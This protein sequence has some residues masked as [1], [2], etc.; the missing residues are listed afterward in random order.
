MLA[1][2]P[3]EIV[4]TGR[5]RPVAGGARRDAGCGIAVL[6]DVLAARDQGGG[7]RRAGNRDLAAVVVR[8][9]SHLLV[10]EW[11]SHAPH[12]AERIGITARLRLEC[13][14]LRRQVLRVLARQHRKFWRIAVAL[15]A[16]TGGTG[17]DGDTL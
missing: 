2:E 13:L 10:T 4:G 11:R 5:R 3:R 16:V 17:T 12:V 15:R 6:I 9:R 14:Q 1:R 8:Q 7:S